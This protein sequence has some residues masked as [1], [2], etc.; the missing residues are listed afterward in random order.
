MKRPQ[1]KLAALVGGVALTL[2][3]AF[4]A[5]NGGGPASALAAT[6][7]ATP[8]ASAAPGQASK[9]DFLSKLAANLGIGQDTLTAAV[10]KTNLQLI[11]EAVA[12]GTMTEAQA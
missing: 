1:M 7:A 3:V 9:T 4:T 10:K 8:G 2:L 11:D 5:L 6:A 12:A